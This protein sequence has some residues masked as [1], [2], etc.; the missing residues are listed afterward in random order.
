MYKLSQLEKRR[1]SDAR[2]AAVR[3]VAAASGQAQTKAADAPV[4]SAAAASQSG[5]TRDPHFEEVL[6]R[7]NT[8]LE[9]SRSAA[10]VRLN[11]LQLQLAYEKF[12]LAEARQ[13]SRRHAINGERRS[14]PKTRAHA[15][16]I[17]RL[18]KEIAAQLQSDPDF[19]YVFTKEQLHRDMEQEH[20]GRLVDVPYLQRARQQIRTSLDAGIPVYLVGHL[21]SGKTQLAVECAED[22]LRERILQAKLSEK[23]AAYR[24]RHP[25]A[26]RRN[27]L[28]YFEQ[29][30]PKAKEEAAGKDCHPY[31]IAG[32][33]NLT[34]EDMFFEKTLKLSHASGNVSNGE[35]LNQLISG[36]TS[37]L[38][39]NEAR[40]KDMK[41]DQ[42]MELMLA[43]WKTFSELYIAEN[44]GYGTTVEKIEKEVLL[45]IREG[46]PIVIDEI[47]TIAMANLIAL[48]DILQHHAGQ[49]A[50]VTGIGSLTI[51]EGFCLI[52]TGNLSTGTVTYE[53]TNVLNPAFQ[54][55][56]T[57]I[58]YNYVP[59]QT[60]GTLEEQ[61]HTDHH[62]ESNELF[63]LLI[64]HLCM[65]DGTLSL[66][67]P[68]ATLPALWRLAQLAR[69]SQNIFE[70][71]STAPEGKGD[72]P[73]LNE[74]VLSV[75]NLIHVLDHWDYGEEEDL[76]MAL[77]NGFLSS[78][79]NP[80]DRNLLLALAARYGFF[81]EPDG[82]HI[83]NRARGDAALTYDEIRT[84]PYQ[85]HLLPL[86]LLSSEDVAILLFGKGPKRR[87]LPPGL[88]K[89]IM[90]DGD[91]M[92]NLEQTQN[93]DATLRHLEHSA[94]VLGQTAAAPEPSA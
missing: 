63:R 64:E 10:A 11:D 6:Q 40:M 35:E 58:V 69:V 93:A 45:A 67:D 71:H 52:G 66:P 79:T 13:D 83:E 48:N 36:F 80:D 61:F 76:S 50:Y 25:E 43:G 38:K 73:V 46:R 56:F 72:T 68:P 21:G 87:Q 5:R 41:P 82:W 53:G 78:V 92:E 1:R 32:S 77:W 84:C 3:T 20:A 57:T 15:E 7:Y 86:E 33:H 51:A 2:A 39:E 9:E 59:Q 88:Q 74:A 37:F 31:F 75:R 81:S 14:T 29:I 60:E 16:Q 94:L 85:H 27:E 4:L 49:T 90:L 70:G 91:P 18:Q 30:Y 8:W 89:E 44:T 54:S 22:Y 47:N 26:S 19:F 12:C 42:Q 28:D 17:Q 24:K 55:R 23:M 62:P 34:A 65:E